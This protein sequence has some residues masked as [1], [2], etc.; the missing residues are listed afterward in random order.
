MERTKALVYVLDGSSADPW[1]D[2]ETVRQEVAQFSAELAKRPHLI[3]VNK[4]DL[5]P[6]RRLR[7]RSR[8]AGVHFVSALAGE[9][10]PTLMEAI[11][12]LVT[13]APE[14]PAPAP[15]RVIRL[16]VLR[17]VDLVV[18]RTPTGF[19]VRGERVESL[20]GRTDLESEGG[21]ARFQ[22]ALDRLGVNT[23]LEAAGV[24]PGETVTIAGV[25]FE[26]QP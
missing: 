6:A 10:L 2:L 22:A 13:S 4:V 17:R 18:E 23:A 8:R 16:P 19:V 5:E 7:S 26:Y 24:T 12:K 15:L 11:A 3:A 9:G 21:L 20:V 1:K 25:E 14:P